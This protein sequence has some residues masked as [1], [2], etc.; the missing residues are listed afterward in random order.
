MVDSCGFGELLHDASKYLDLG[1][2]TTVSLVS[3]SSLFIGLNNLKY[4]RFIP[5]GKTDIFDL[6]NITINNNRVEYTK[7]ML[8]ALKSLENVNV[9]NKHGHS[10]LNQCVPRAELIKYLIKLGADINLGNPLITAA[11]YENIESVNILINAGADINIT[12]HTPTNPKI[13]DAFIKGG[14]DL[15]FKNLHRKKPRFL[16]GD[17][18]WTSDLEE[19]LIYITYLTNIVKSTKLL[20]DSGADLEEDYIKMRKKLIGLLD[21]SDIFEFLG[22]LYETDFSRK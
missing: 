7:L 17:G 19:G 8:R 22:D 21:N 18:V 6:M 9:I 3:T 1:Q 12:Q 15:S 13:L 4:N 14:L 5:D 16:G 20:I 2:L 10:L 11:G